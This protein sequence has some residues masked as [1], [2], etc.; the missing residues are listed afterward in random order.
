MISWRVRHRTSTVRTPTIHLAWSSLGYSRLAT[1]FLIGAVA[2]GVGFQIPNTANLDGYRAELVKH[3][4]TAGFGHVRVRPTETSYI[5]QSAAL[6]ARLQALPD[7]RGASVVLAFPGALGR[8]SGAN[9]YRRNAAIFGIDMARGNRPFTLKSGT[10]V[11]AG[12]ARG[13]VVGASLAE[14][15]D[16]QVGDTV[17]VHAIFETPG[18]PLSSAGD[19]D[20]LSLDGGLSPDGAD[21][22][23]DEGGEE[24]VYRMT[25]RGLSVGTYSAARS[26]FIDYQ[27]AARESGLTDSASMILLY[28]N[29]LGATARV[30]STVAAAAPDVRA[31]TW[32]QDD[33]FIRSA[34]ESSGSI[35]TISESMV[36]FAVAIPVLALMYI[37]VWRRRRDIGL[38]GAI[39]FSPFAV[40]RIFLWQAVFVGLLGIAI[41]CA[42]GYGL[43]LYFQAN[44]LF[45][46][47][48]F[49]LRPVL[50]WQGVVRP[51][52]I[53]LLV[54]VGAS[55][56]PAWRAARMDPARV[57]RELS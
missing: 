28:L 16:L 18:A 26:L 10:V 9:R 27:F 34:I 3:S 55:T 25:V 53:V 11:A 50:T 2:A 20:G 31:S 17:E 38:L 21:D 49:V 29:D 37:Q 15:F 35:G 23:D 30:A 5:D 41:G 42:L 8:A 6:G 46:W 39:G 51:A 33:T 40:F 1:A 19:G 24:G 44:V 57:L 48:S 45:E 43:V 7:V 4:V 36:V 13:V 47:E 52:V 54:T 56:Y 12:D 32:L 22:D 14:R